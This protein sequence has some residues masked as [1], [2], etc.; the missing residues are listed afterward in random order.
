MTTEHK[1]SPIYPQHR[2]ETLEPH[3]SLHVSAMTTEQLHH[4]SDIAEQ[5]AWRDQAIDALRAR[6]EELEAARLVPPADD[7]D[8]LK[9]VDCVEAD[10]VA[11]REA[12]QREERIRT[13]EAEL[14]EV[15]RENAELRANAN[16][17]WETG[18]N[19]AIGE[20]DR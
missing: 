9:H 17:A 18:F 6:V 16:R 4:K 19:A 14:A 11:T 13:L 2:L 20:E 8:P 5:L 10:R 1:P 12:L 7:C 3:Y 15:R